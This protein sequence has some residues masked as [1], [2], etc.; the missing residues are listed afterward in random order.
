M[1]QKKHKINKDDIR[2][3]IGFYLDEVELNISVKDDLTG[4]KEDETLH[5]F[6]HIQV[7]T[8]HI[9]NEDCSWD[10]L[11][12]FISAGK[13]EFKEECKKEL[14]QKGFEDWKDI[15]KKVKTLLKRAKKLNLLT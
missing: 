2:T 8:G 4:Y 6:G 15:Y 9:N 13:K 5:N 3:Y 14:Q 10:N 12:F 7:S 1:K 11:S